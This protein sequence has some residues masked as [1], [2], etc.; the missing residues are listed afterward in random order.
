MK[1]AGVLADFDDQVLCGLDPESIVDCGVEHVGMWDCVSAVG[2]PWKWMQIFSDTWY[3]KV[4]GRRLWGL[5][6]NK[7]SGKVRQGHH[8]LALDEEREPFLPTRWDR[9]DNVKEV[10]YAGCHGDVG[11]GEVDCGLSRIPLTDMIRWAEERGLGFHRKLK[12]KFKRE[13]DPAAGAHDSRSTPQG[14]LLTYRTREADH[15]TETV[16]PSVWDRV[17]NGAEYYAPKPFVPPEGHMDEWSKHELAE[18]KVAFAW[19]GILADIVKARVKTKNLSLAFFASAAVYT[20][21]SQWFEGSKTVSEWLFDKINVAMPEFLVGVPVADLAVL[22]LVYAALDAVRKRV[23]RLETE[24]RFFAWRPQLARQFDLKKRWKT[25]LGELAKTA[26]W[27]PSK[28]I[29]WPVA[30]ALFVGAAWLAN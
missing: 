9:A 28:W 13:A 1:E 7:L 25:A 30:I 12:N 26:R 5:H 24:I 8:A 20:F 19:D 27:T 2:F 10:W 4:F 15:R 6:D 23:K 22:G 21:W 11:G 29:S 14:F 18:E 16:C 17:K 3:R